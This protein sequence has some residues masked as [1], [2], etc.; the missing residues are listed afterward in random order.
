[1]YAARRYL[2]EHP[3]VIG[4]VPVLLDRG[5]PLARDFVLHTAMMADTPELN[6]VLRDFTL[7]QH[8]KDEM[9]MQTAQH[10]V[11]AGV[12]PSGLTRLWLK[13]EW[14]DLLLIG[15]ELHGEQVYRHS[16]QVERI[17]LEAG[18]ALWENDGER[19]ERLFQTGGET[20]TRQA[21][22]AL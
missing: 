9:R 14:T 3:E 17:A 22:F 5:D 4:L 7:G 12:M 15:F 16:A 19:A 1:M 6:A 21:R 10:C 20:R 2:R 18:K 8:G 13:G 11:K